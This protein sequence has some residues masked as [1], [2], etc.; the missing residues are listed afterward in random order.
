MSERFV[1][2]L[3]RL[4]FALFFVGIFIWI[5]WG[6]FFG[7]GNET[8]AGGSRV[9]PLAIGVPALVLAL[10]AFV[11][12]LRRRPTQQ[13]AEPFEL[14]PELQQEEVVLEPAVVRRRTLVIIAW[15]AG[16]YATMHLLGFMIA[17]PLLT[18]LY[19]R[20]AGKEGWP[21]AITLAVVAWF[22][23]DGIF[24]GYLNIP[25]SERVD[26]LLVRKF[27]ETASVDIT[28]RF[29][30]PADWLAEKFLSRKGLI[31]SAG[32]VVAGLSVV[33][34]RPFLGTKLSSGLRWPGRRT[35][36]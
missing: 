35:A 8:G 28:S 23:F 14:D 20:F 29:I 11:L 22:F 13:S 6:A 36:Q 27:E 31:V 32:I 34:G 15:I 10:M 30:D 33:F 7:Y 25:L 2:R 16:F 12:E 17:A 26:G 5:L 21:M 19:V 24:D 3:P 1:E 18:L 4:L 9:F